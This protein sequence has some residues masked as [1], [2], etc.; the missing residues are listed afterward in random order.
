MYESYILIYHI[1]SYT[2]CQI[3]KTIY[4]DVYIIYIYIYRY[5][6]TN[7][8]IIWGLYFCLNISM[9]N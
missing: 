3:S 7:H 5:E 6:I 8:I 4:H 9:I 2:T 1:L